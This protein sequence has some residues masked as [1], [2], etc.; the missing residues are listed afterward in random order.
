MPAERS[1]ENPTTVVHRVFRKGSFAQ[2]PQVGLKRFELGHPAL[3]G[4]IESKDST[5][6][7]SLDL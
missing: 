2:V 5:T 1:G 4:F 7:R 3:E 6:P